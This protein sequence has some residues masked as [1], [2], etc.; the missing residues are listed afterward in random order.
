VHSILIDLKTDESI[1]ELAYEIKSI[2]ST[3]IVRNWSVPGLGTIVEI[4][5]IF[6]SKGTTLKYLSSYYGIPL[7]RCLAFGD[8]DND[9]EMLRTAYYGFAMFNGTTT[10]KLSAGKMTRHTNNEDG[11]ARELKAFFK[12]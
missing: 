4:N 2:T 7:N 10:A 6:S 5:S 8:G 11:V 12:V 3:L 9:S 1:N